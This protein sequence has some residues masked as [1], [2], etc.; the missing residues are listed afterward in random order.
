MALRE[1]RLK[2]RLVCWYSNGSASL[3]AAKR[4]IEMQPELYPDHQ[5]VVARIY[6]KE[7]YHEPERDEL[8][9]LFLGHKILDMR[10]KKHS[11]SVDEVIRIHRY[12]SGVAGAKCTKVLKKAV[13]LNWQ[14]DSDVHVFGFDCDEGERRI[15]NLLDTEPE[16][17]YFAPLVELGMTKKD[18]FS[19]QLEVGIPLSMM[20]KL[21]YH[22]NNC[23]GCVKAGGAG[24]WNKI[25]VDFPDVFW[26]RARQEELL[27][28]AMV[29]MSRDKFMKL[30]PDHFARMC[31]EWE[32]R[33][34]TTRVKRRGGYA[35]YH[36]SLIPLRFLPEDAGD[37]KDLDIGDCGFICEM[38][39]N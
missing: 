34:K 6:L 26:N 19:E 5:I 8:V 13:R 14:R 29:S 18:C 35:D 17:N 39:G 27:N 24:Y 36:T 15:N 2:P 7:E 12:M 21:G 1:R 4:A 28:T 3:I 11:A 25:R 38:K 23:I 16:I 31:E 33:Y 9:E 32:D 20:Y 10:D 30:W 37:H 22:N